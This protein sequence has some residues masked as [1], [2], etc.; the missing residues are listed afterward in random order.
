MNQFPRK[1][2]RA[3]QAQTTFDAR[4]ERVQS[5]LLHTAELIADTF[6]ERYT[7]VQAEPEAPIA[8]RRRAMA[9]A[10]QIWRKCPRRTCGHARA[11]RGEPA[12]CLQACFPA[13]PD[14][15]FEA[16]VAESRRRRKR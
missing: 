10:L 13:L 7:D 3:T 11:C 6:A 4:L 16:Y 12:H 15:T 1:P 5:K 8:V 9:N 14:G 2:A